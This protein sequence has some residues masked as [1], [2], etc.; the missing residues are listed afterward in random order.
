M[1]RLSILVGRLNK[2]LAPTKYF[3]KIGRFM[4]VV[5]VIRRSVESPLEAL[6][7]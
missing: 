5:G 6:D 7:P 1:D 3:Q 4:P 2:S